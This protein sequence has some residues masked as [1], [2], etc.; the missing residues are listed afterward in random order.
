MGFSVDYQGLDYTDHFFVPSVLVV[1]I[2]EMKAK[3]DI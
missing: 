3:S 1:V 2:S